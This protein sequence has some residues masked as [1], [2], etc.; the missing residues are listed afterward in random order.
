[1]LIHNTVDPLPLLLVRHQ[2]EGQ[3]FTKRPG[4]VL[5]RYGPARYCGLKGDKPS[6]EKHDCPEVKEEKQDT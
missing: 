3:E 4:Q 1:M 6:L 5:L 2:R